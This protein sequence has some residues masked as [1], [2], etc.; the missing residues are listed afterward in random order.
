MA[1]PWSNSD[2][3]FSS[4]FYSLQA[5]PV[6]RSLECEIAWLLKF[7]FGNLWY[8]ARFWLHCIPKRWMWSCEVPKQF[9]NGIDHGR[10]IC[11]ASTPIH[12]N[13][14]STRKWPHQFSWD[15]L[16]ILQI[17]ISSLFV[18]RDLFHLE[19][20]KQVLTSHLS[21]LRSI[22]LSVKRVPDYEL[23]SLPATFKVSKVSL[24]SSITAS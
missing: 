12:F 16:S 7:F 15:I 13:A 10:M 1:V 5:Q 24:L 18:D 19:N 23:S 20:R 2:T 4:R 9:M 3:G 11:D 21:E 8:Y 17:A 6:W 22:R 14:Q